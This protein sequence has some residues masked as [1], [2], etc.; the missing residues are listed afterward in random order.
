MTTSRDEAAGAGLLAVFTTTET[1]EEARTMASVV[2]ERRLAAC[3][4]ISE[5]ESIY[6]WKG[7]MRRE[8][9]FRLLLKTTKR[10]YAAV[11]AVIRELHPY[12]LPAIFA[13]GVEHAWGPY[14]EWVREGAQGG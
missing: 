7:D 9:E 5:I 1:R 11:E 13:V 6:A 2:V 12:E 10:Q 3:A 8:I 14:A 4:Q